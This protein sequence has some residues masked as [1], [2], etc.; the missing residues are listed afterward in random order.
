[1]PQRASNGPYKRG[2]G[3]PLTRRS[4]L[5]LGAATI[6]LASCR[7]LGDRQRLKSSARIVNQGTVIEC[8]SSN[9]GTSV[10]S[11]FRNAATQ[12]E[13]TTRA[14]L[15]KPTFEYLGGAP[16]SW[17]QLSAKSNEDSIG[18]RASAA[19]GIQGQLSI[20]KY[21]DTGAFRWQQEYLNL[22]KDPI[23]AVSSISAL[24]LD[25]KADLGQVVVHCVRRDG[26]YNREAQPFGTHLE[27]GGGGWN[28]PAYA[29]LILIE[30]VGRSE[31]LI[32]G[33]QQER[34]W[35]L[36]LDQL[37]DRVRLRVTLHE[38]E[39]DI[40]P[41]KSLA[42]CPI[43][44]GT[45]NGELDT[46]VNVALEHLRTR[47]LPPALDGAPWV[48]YNIWSTDAKGVEGN[49]LDEI[50]V[51]AA[52]GVDLFYLDASW[53]SGSSTTG[54][55]DWGKGIGSYKEDR[56]KF[57]LGLRHLSDRVHAAGMKFGLWVGPNIVD[58]TLV[59]HEV[60]L[61][62]LALVDG[63]PAELAIPTWEHKCMQVCLGSADYAEHL[64]HSLARL[65]EDYN[66]DWIKW[67][68]SGIPALPARC[69][70]SDH[71]HRA[72]DGSASALENEYSIFT[73]LNRAFP[74]LALE[75]C[76]YGSRLDYGLAATIRAN[77]CSDTCYPAARLRSNSLVCAT[78]YPSSYNAAW[79]VREDTELFEAKTDGLIDASIRSRMIGLFGVGTLNGQMSQRAS[80]YPRN[81]L[82]RLAYNIGLYKQFRHLLGQRVS[83][84][85]KPYGT[86]PQ[87]WQAVQ[88][89]SSDG[90]QAVLL[91]FR[92]TSSQMASRLVLSGLHPRKAYVIRFVDAKADSKVYG[93]DLMNIG[94]II[95]LPEAGAS[96][97]VMVAEA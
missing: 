94:V 62:W 54:N 45:C 67:D 80:L 52:L 92:G 63:K 74:N 55:G 32:V 35:T 36:S 22:G 12:F 90:L 61:S 68:N 44:I 91:C 43:F 46:A 81:I 24:D 21:A 84:P 77:W 87:G 57:P 25:L 79:V 64:K 4:V 14:Q 9:Y 41:Q 51:A 93:N 20:F 39:K 37:H 71:G 1:M 59:P 19:N 29:G 40:E 30:V 10:L 53:Y 13:W 83:F 82:D 17:Q 85:Y 49:I 76:G 33:V 70:R 5:G 96:E 95:S 47:L 42:A 89:T 69:N 31:F 3:A 58:A 72:N 75:Q 28:S 2:H 7:T 66:L 11:S 48:S 27:I 50:P 86:D 34:G 60:P 8:S 56:S 73:Y 97:V 16:F 26:D 65:I 18:I 6:V 78:V 38:M 88:F 23:L 15:F